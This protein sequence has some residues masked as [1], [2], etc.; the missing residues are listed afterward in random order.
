MRER[1]ELIGGSLTAGPS[2]EGFGVLL[3][4]PV[5]RGGAPG[6]TERGGGEPD[7]VNGQGEDGGRRVAVRRM[8]R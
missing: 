3:R 6:G 2:G 7:D 1:A 8:T 4:V 5:R